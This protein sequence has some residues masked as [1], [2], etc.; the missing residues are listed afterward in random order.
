MKTCITEMAFLGPL[1]HVYPVSNYT[2]GSKVA[3]AD[4]DQTPADMF[5]RMQA[6][7]GLC[8]H[9]AHPEAV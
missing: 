8:P 3:T 9:S 7:Y 6:G 4:K 5:A 2:F 1:L